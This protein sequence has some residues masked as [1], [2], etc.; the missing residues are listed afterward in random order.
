M[1][2]I[3]A[4]LTKVRRIVIVMIR[5]VTVVMIMITVMIIVIICVNHVRY[6]ADI[7]DMR[8]R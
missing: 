5:L 6:E 2:I 7:I 4:I 1:M 8:I 3:A